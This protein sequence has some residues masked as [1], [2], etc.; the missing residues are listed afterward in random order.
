VSF[1]ALR[2][3]IVSDAGWRAGQQRQ[4][5]SVKGEERTYLGQ[6]ISLSLQPM[7][8]MARASLAGTRL[9]PNSDLELTQKATEDFAC[10][11]ME[12]FSA[13]DHLC[14]CK[15]DFLSDFKNVPEF[16]LA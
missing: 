4:D 3:R 1:R 6:Q 12:A 11:V 13:T 14:H 9:I 16:H 2:R 5:K 8:Y 15:R 7:Q 10:C